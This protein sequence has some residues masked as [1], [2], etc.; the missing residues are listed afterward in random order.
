MQ[1]YF[2]TFEGPEGSGKTITLHRISERLGSLGLDV[3]TT[4]EPGG[5]PIG[6]QFRAIAHDMNNENLSNW[7]S[8]WAYQGSR[9]QHVHELIYSA[10][11]K[12]KIVLCDRYTDSTLAYQGYGWGLGCGRL[13]LVNQWEK[14]V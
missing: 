11:E 12:G 3:V 2:I 1:G 6:D 9:A 10:L 8:A 14:V 5:T 4:R 13:D 7:A